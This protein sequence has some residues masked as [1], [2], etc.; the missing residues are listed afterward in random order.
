MITLE[1][2]KQVNA[3]SIKE[4]DPKHVKN[5]FCAVLLAAVEDYCD[6]TSVATRRTLPDYIFSKKTIRRD[7]RNPKLI[8][9]TDG[10]SIT[11]LDALK[12][13]PQQIKENLK[14]V[15]YCADNQ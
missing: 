10:M 8:A 14:D 12:T 9:L 4:Y 3:S 11:V 2:A 7:L 1:K 5:L 6:E 13:R 15:L